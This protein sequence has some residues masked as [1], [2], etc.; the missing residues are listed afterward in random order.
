MS[1]KIII[2]GMTITGGN[3]ISIVNGRIIVD[4]K[5]QTPDAKS[6][7]I[8]ILGDVQNLDVDHSDSISIEGNVGKIKSGSGDITCNNIMGDAQTGSG[9]IKCSEIKGDVQTGSGDVD[10]NGSISGSVRT[11]SGDISYKK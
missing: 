9:D 5:D 6:I 8:E 7:K 11:G 1:P 4:G 3:N 2:N 10:C